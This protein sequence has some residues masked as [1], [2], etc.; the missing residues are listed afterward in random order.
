[1]KMRSIGGA[2]IAATLIHAATIAVFASA[3]QRPTSS[4]TSTASDFKSSYTK[5]PDGYGTYG[6]DDGGCYHC[7]LN[8]QIADAPAM[9]GSNL[10]M[11]CQQM[12]EADVDC[13]AYTVGRTA[14]LPAQDYYYG[15]RANCCLERREYPSGVFVDAHKTTP[16]TKKKSACQ[17]ESM[18]WTRYEKHKQISTQQTQSCSGALNDKP[19]PSP[20]CKPVWKANVYTEQEIKEKIDFIEQGCQYNDATFEAMLVK[21]HDQCQAE[22]FGESISATMIVTK[23]GMLTRVNVEP[24]MWSRMAELES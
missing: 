19:K 15:K 8:P 13:I 10:Q 22:I 23:T 18:C 14:S 3:Q 24:S 5:Y 9:E 7:T 21:A 16:G 12:C 4:P 2:M 1:M 17:H 11:H 6:I 20:K